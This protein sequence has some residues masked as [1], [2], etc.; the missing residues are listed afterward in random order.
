MA[1]SIKVWPAN[2]TAFPDFFKNSTK[3]WWKNE[4]KMLYD[5]IKF[6]AMWIV[7]TLLKTNFT[8]KKPLSYYTARVAY[9]D[10]NEVSNFETGEEGWLQC[11]TNKWDDPPYETSKIFVQYNR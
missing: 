2:K 8:I 6:D 9:Q 7:S 1:F 11:P 10:M 3:I 4:I 5:K